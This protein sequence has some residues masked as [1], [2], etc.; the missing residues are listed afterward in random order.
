[1]AKM[2][3]IIKKMATTEQQHIHCGDLECF[4]SEFKVHYW[5]DINIMGL[6]CVKCGRTIQFEIA[7][8]DTNWIKKEFNFIGA[9]VLTS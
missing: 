3:A 6:M 4:G 5:T 9:N 8:I 2:Q 7:K 1:M